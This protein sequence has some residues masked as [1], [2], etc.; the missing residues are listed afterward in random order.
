M[1]PKGYD[2]IFDLM[3]E[4]FG[5]EKE[6]SKA[7]I[8]AYYKEVRKEIAEINTTRINI[9]GLGS[10]DLKHFKIKYKLRDTI[11][12]IAYHEKKKS[13]R[14]IA[15]L[16]GLERKLKILKRAKILADE[17]EKKGNEKRLARKEYVAKN[18]KNLEE[19]A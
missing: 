5:L 12:F 16:I 18:H 2:S 9:I 11:N 15:I 1:N 4:K 8:N 19:Q 3:Q 17:R 14:A 6:F 7:L 10:F 13:N